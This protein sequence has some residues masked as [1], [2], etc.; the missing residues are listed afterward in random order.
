MEWNRISELLDRYWEGE[1]TV[2]E[3]AEL[4]IAFARPDVPAHLK[5]AATL[6]QYYTTEQCKEILDES[7]DARLLIR[8][9]SQTGSEIN[10]GLPEK[11]ILKLDS[12]RKLFTT[13]IKL[14]ACLFVVLGAA[15]FYQAE[16]QK[17]REKQQVVQLEETYDDPQKAYEETKKAL[18]LV[19]AHLNK[20]K[21]YVT[22]IKRIDQAQELIKSDKKRNL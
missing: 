11:P 2:E 10:S 5:E 21:A 1:T 7:F 6:F 17:Q 15:L 8:L 20:G 4:K 16:Q 22:E 3:E 12:R 19:S 14:A 18:L 9:E 13:L